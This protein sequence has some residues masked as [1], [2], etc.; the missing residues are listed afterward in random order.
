MTVKE[1][2]SGVDGN[3]MEI[4][5]RFLNDDKIR[6]YLYIFL[7]DKTFTNLCIEIDSKNPQR[8]FIYA[9]TLKVLSQNLSLTPLY[10]K[11]QQITR[12]LR[13]NNIKNGIGFPG[14]V[15]LKRLH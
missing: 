6:K 1:F 15:F 12:A 3:Y 2:Y 8:A 7:Q 5:S 9:H 14:T 11:S 4:Y 10:M 13:N